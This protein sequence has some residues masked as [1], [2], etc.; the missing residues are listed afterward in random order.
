MA[1]NQPP[2]SGGLVT[3]ITDLRHLKRCCTGPY[4]TSRTLD[5]IV[6]FENMTQSKGSFSLLSRLSMLT[7]EC[8][9]SCIVTKQEPIEQK[10]IARTHGHG[11]NNLRQVQITG[12]RPPYPKL[13][14][15]QND[16]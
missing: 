11:S 8:P 7:I 3:I 2:V 9:D 14:A 4:R 6:A 1:E 16:R 5:V 13:R 10:K 12:R 15:L